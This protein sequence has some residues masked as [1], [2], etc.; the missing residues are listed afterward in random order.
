MPEITTVAVNCPAV[1]CGQLP[2]VLPSFHRNETILVS[3]RTDAR[4]MLFRDPPQII[5][6]LLLAGES[7]EQLGSALR[8]R[9]KIEGLI[10][11]IGVVLQCPATACQ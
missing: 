8:K 2:A 1:G 11:R 9:V 4:H 6:N 7:S 5:K 3:N 10:Q